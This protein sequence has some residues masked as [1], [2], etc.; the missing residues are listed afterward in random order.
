MKRQTFDEFLLETAQAMADNDMNSQRAADSIYISRNGFLYRLD[1]IK[2]RT[3]LDLRSFK[4]LC[5]ILGYEK[6][7][8]ENES[9]ND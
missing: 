2:K 5:E 8:I 1:A 7:V 9:E 4:T 3:G 6:K